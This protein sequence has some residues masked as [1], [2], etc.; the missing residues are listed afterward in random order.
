MYCAES[1][2]A[3][4]K[5]KLSLHVQFKRFGTLGSINLVELFQGPLLPPHNDDR[6][7]LD[8]Q[9]QGFITDLL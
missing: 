7:D 9:N 2:L 6:D 3:A 8:H 5:S 1:L 4:M